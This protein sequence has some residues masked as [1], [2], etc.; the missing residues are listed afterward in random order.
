MPGSQDFA[1]DPRNERALV[2]LNGALV[3][4]DQAKVSILD[5]HLDRLFWGASRI[6]LDIGLDRVRLEAAIRKTLDA[7]AMKDGVHLRIMVTRGEKTAANQDPRN[8]LGKATVVILAEHK[9]P[10]PAVSARGLSLANATIRCTPANMFDMRL[11]SHSRL[12]L[13]TALL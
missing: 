1:A 9:V 13:I 10:D 6:R 12:N 8:A 2:Y 5:A 7:H 11:N 3:P 4:R